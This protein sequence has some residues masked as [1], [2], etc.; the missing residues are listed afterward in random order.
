MAKVQLTVAE[1]AQSASMPVA[2]LLSRLKDNKIKANKDTLVTP[3]IRKALLSA[4]EQAEDSEAPKKKTLSL[5]KKPTLS[6]GS[7]SGVAAVTVK[8]KRRRYEKPSQETLQT[9]VAP[10]SVVKPEKEESVAVEPSKVDSH[11]EASSPDLEKSTIKKTVTKPKASTSTSAATESKLKVPNKKSKLPK[12]RGGAHSHKYDE[13]AFL[14]DDGEESSPSR[15]WRR[16][17]AYKPADQGFIKP[18][19][20]KV[21]KVNVPENITVADLAQK[22][23]IKPAQ[24]IAKMMEMGTM[25]TINQLVDQETAMVIVEE[26]GHVPVALKE[27]AMEEDLLLASENT[28][29]A[30]SRAPVVTIMG[31]VDHGKTSLLDKIRTSKVTDSEAGG[32][33]QHIGAYQVATEKGT[34]TFLDTPGHEAFTAMRA[35]G[36][37][38]T[39]IVVLVVA[40]DDGVMPQTKEAIQHAR[41]GNVPM[42]VA[43]NKMDKPEADPD[44][45]MSELAANDVMAEEWGGDVIF[46]KL[47][48]KTGEGIDALLDAILLQAEVMELTAVAEGPAKGIIV[49]S[50]LDRGRGPVATMLIQAGL[51]HPGDI[52]L[53]GQEYGKVRA[54]LGDYGQK[55]EE[56]GPGMPVE[57][58]GL[59]GVP[60]AGDDALAVNHERKAREVA[61][62]RQGRYRQ[63]SLA[64]G[65]TKLDDVYAKMSEGEVS[66]LNVV[67]KADVQGS[68]EAINDAL[69]KLSTDEVKVT[70]VASAVGGITESDVNLA[71]ASKSILI[72]FNVRANVMAR[73]IIEKEQVDLHYYSVIYTLIDEVKNA[74]SG[75]LAPE[76]KEVILGLAEVREVYRSSK[77]GSI[78]G[79]IVQEGVVKRNADIRVLRDNIV[80]YQ[81]QLESL[82]RFKEDAVEVKQGIECGIGVKDYNDVKTGDQIEAYEIQKI[83]RTL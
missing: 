2:Q 29:Q 75:L 47:S 68:L 42:I 78:A 10:K 31:H 27:N 82:R 25:A 43:V 62:F 57:V 74:L 76:E 49:E 15:G 56:A 20:P 1:L 18:V 14:G 58:L 35:R 55:I 7:K 30:I 40:A 26:M 77:W 61:L 36:A 44:K 66:H 16:K 52:L 64:K 4:S 53:A 72:G 83:D 11:D 60:N 3:D 70:I 28:G 5:K 73:R 41:S 71:I 22:M 63:V 81:G 45:V 6:L 51:L 13:V 80:I 17:K 34:I 8:A 39:D 37:Q 59:S 24:V 9:E 67:L 50:R 69:T 54:M 46:Q 12:S 23:S 79:C 19:T 33:T 38:C 65:S 48:A 32:I 21:N